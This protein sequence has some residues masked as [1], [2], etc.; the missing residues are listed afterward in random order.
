MMGNY[1]PGDLT[2]FSE[3]KRIIPNTYVTFDGN[4]HVKRFYPYHEIKMCET[5]EEYRQVIEEASRVS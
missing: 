2:C 3:L 4:Y 5:E 1:M